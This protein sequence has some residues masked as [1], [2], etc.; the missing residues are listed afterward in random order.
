ML[1]IYVICMNQKRWSFTPDMRRD[2]LTNYS[3]LLSDFFTDI[4]STCG[5]PE[6]KI[7]VV[8]ATTRLKENY[9]MKSS[10]I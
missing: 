9:Q 1:D 8:T 7:I 6:A 5:Q 4:P 3:R 10:R 2:L